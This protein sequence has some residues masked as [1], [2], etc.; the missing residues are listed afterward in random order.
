MCVKIK[1]EVKHKSDI[2]VFLADDVDAFGRLAVFLTNWH[3]RV[4]NLEGEAPLFCE[5]LCRSEN[6]S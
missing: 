4:T 3:L 6:N 5:I 1:K 2:S